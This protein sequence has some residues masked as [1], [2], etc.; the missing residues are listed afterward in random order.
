M[1]IGDRDVKWDA[2]SEIHNLCEKDFHFQ[3]KIIENGEL[4]ICSFRF[5]NQEERAVVRVI[6]LELR[7][8]LKKL[9]LRSTA[10]SVYDFG[11]IVIDLKKIVKIEICRVT[12]PTEFKITFKNKV[13]HICMDWVWTAEELANLKGAL[14]LWTDN[15]FK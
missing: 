9:L 15:F 14:D 4:K 11:G 12:G 3:F 10:S 2:V 7:K 1:L 6:V 5:N 13:F 8:Q